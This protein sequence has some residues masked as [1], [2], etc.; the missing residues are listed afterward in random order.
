MLFELCIYVVVTTIRKSTA[1][2]CHHNNEYVK[3]QILLHVMEMIFR[4]R[5][6]A[7]RT[8]DTGVGGGLRHWH[9]RICQ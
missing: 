6:L 2:L 3:T 8:I 5:L 9:C 1:I 4:A 7:L